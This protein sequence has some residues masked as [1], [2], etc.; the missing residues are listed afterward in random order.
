M[1]S[2][3]R[4][5]SKGSQSATATAEGS[6]APSPP[7]PPERR[8]QVAELCGSPAQAAHL[9]AT[10]AR[11][12]KDPEW[13]DTTASS[14]SPEWYQGL[15]PEPP[16]PPTKDDAPA[17]KRRKVWPA[18]AVVA[19]LSITAG[20]VWQSAADE[21]Q[22]QERSDKAAAYKGR[23]GAALRI[24]G[25]STDLVAHWSSDRDKVVIELRSY[26]DKNARYLRLDAGGESTS[27][28]RQDGCYPKAP[29][30][31]VPMSDPLADVTVRVAVGGKTWK[32]GADVEGRR[33]R[34]LPDRAPVTDWCRLRR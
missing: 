6:G 2:W 17:R 4:S 1:C 3:W 23:S 30:I 28:K 29:E 7:H 26:F 18:V 15:P 5:G 32:D 27:S 10:V 14:T 31:A 24:D 34:R 16:A 12:G 9:R 13:Y 21:D 25:V 8:A 11:M 19:A 22:R 20:G 33:T